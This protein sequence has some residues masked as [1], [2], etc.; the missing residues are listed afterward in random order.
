[1]LNKIKRWLVD[2]AVRLLENR[3]IRTWV[4]TKALRSDSLSAKIV[5]TLSAWDDETQRN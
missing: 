2:I 5:D 4:F 3:K 1:M